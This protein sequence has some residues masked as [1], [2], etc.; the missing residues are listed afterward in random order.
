MSPPPPLYQGTTLDDTMQLVMIS[1]DAEVT[2]SPPPDPD[3]VL[4]DTVQL[5]KS[6]GSISL[7]LRVALSLVCGC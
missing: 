5:I 2:K 4:D 6:T 1:I 3:T 7:W